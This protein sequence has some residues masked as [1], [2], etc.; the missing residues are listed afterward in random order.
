MLSEAKHLAPD[1]EPGFAASEISH[2]VTRSF[3]G[4]QDDGTMLS[5]HSLVIL[6]AGGPRLARVAGANKKGRVG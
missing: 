6:A 3:A 4:A 5:S 2:S 1:R